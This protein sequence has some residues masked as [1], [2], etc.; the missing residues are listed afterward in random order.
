MKKEI[1]ANNGTRDPGPLGTAPA[2]GHVTVATPVPG[3]GIRPYPG[4]DVIDRANQLFNFW[5]VIRACRRTR[6]RALAEKVLIWNQ[7]ER[8]PPGCQG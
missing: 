1:T 7:Q 6:D 4:F 5:L 3:V 8:S 2:A